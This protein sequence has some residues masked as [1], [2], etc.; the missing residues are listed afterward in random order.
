MDKRISAS[1][2]SAM[3]KLIHSQLQLLSTHLL[4]E[5]FIDICVT[6]SLYVTFSTVLFFGD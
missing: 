1:F 4:N 5:I 6:H 2:F 3:E